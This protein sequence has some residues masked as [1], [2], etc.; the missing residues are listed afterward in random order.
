MPSKNIVKIYIKDGI[1]HIYNRGVEKR[2]IFMDEQDYKVFLNLLKRYL[3]PPE[4][5]YHKKTSL[6]I[7]L[8]VEPVRRLPPIRQSDIDKKI[9]LL[10]YCLMPN[11]FHLMIQ[12]LTERAIIDFMRR[13]SNSYTKYF[14]EKYKRVGS[15]FQ[16]RY[17]AALVTKEEHFLYLPYYI[18]RNPE[19][20][21]KKIKNYPY[22]SYG[23][24]IG[25]RNTKWIYK[26]DLME[27]FVEAENEDVDFEKAKDILG[28]IALE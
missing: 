6:Q 14:N 13:L 10:C 8:Q 18:H 21:N 4:D 19:K 12:Q 27:Q 9:R 25:T 5:F 16:G 24:Y 20:L 23:D 3:T 2:K 26:K 17:K 11:H 28:K 1:Y 7:P 15:L 22:S